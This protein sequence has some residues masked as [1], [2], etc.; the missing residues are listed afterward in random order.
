MAKKCSIFIGVIF[1]LSMVGLWG[2]GRVLETQSA[3]NYLL[4]RLNNH[5][6]GRVSIGSLD[7][8]LFRGRV[9][10]ENLTVFGPGQREIARAVGLSLDLSWLGFLGGDLLIESIQVDTPKIVLEAAQ[11]GALN[12]SSVFMDSP[13]GSVEKMKPSFSFPLNIRLASL[14]MTNGSLSLDQKL[15]SINLTSLAPEMLQWIPKGELG[16]DLSVKGPLD[17]PAIYLSLESKGL[18]I[19]GISIRDL[20]FMAGMQNQ[21]INIDRFQLE[22]DLG[23]FSIDGSINLGSMFPK[24]FLQGADP[25]NLSYDLKAQLEGLSPEGLNALGLSLPLDIKDMAGSLAAGINIKGAGILPGSI[26]ADINADAELQG[27]LYQDLLKPVGGTLKAGARLEGTHASLQSLNL[28]LPCLKLTGTGSLDMDT[29]EADGKFLLAVHALDELD[30]FI[31]VGTKG[32][33][34]TEAR[35]KGILPD[36]KIE[37]IAQG[38][39]LEIQGIRLGNMDL[40]ADLESDGSLWIDQVRLENQDGVL[41]GSGRIG[42]FD[43]GFDLKESL[44]MDMKLTLENLPLSDFLLDTDME[45]RLNGVINLTGTLDSPIVRT[46]VKG[47]DLAFGAVVFG[48]ASVEGH[49]E[50]GLFSIN[51]FLLKNKESELLAIGS[52]RILDSDSGFVSNPVI[53]LDIQGRGILFQDLVPD[54]RGQVDLDAQLRGHLFDPLVSLSLSGHGIGLKTYE[55]G[56][57]TLAG[58]LKKGQLS[59]DRG[60]VKNKQS[61][62]DLTASVQIFDPVTMELKPDPY[63]ALDINEGHIFLD[64]FME[65]AAGTVTVFGNVSGQLSNMTGRLGMKTGSLRVMGQAM[66]EGIVEASVKGQTIEIDRAE[67]W[68]KN[69]SVIKA[70]GH[71]TPMTQ[72]FDIRVNSKQFN[73]GDLTLARQY[74]ID[75]GLVSLD[76]EARGRFD[77]PLV[78]ADIKVVDL[79]VQGEA[80]AGFDLGLHLKEQT[81]DIQGHVRDKN[82]PVSDK[83]GQGSAGGSKITGQYHL[84]TQAFS[85]ALELKNFYLSPYFSLAGRP[86]FSGLITGQFLAQGLAGQLDHINV[87]ADVADLNVT[88]A[89]QHFLSM[90]NAGFSIDDGKIH[91]PPVRISLYKG[92]IIQAKGLGDMTGGLDF[93][94][95]GEV[96]LDM[97]APLVP[98]VESASGTISMEAFVSGSLTDPRIR[99]TLDL[100]NLGLVLDGIE[101]EIKHVKG[102]VQMD[103]DQIEII[104]VA[105]NLDDGRFDLNG[106]VGI[107]RWAPDTLDLSLKSR[108][109]EVDIPDLMEMS[110]NLDL[111]LKGTARASELKGAV[112]ILQGRYYR[113]V[114]LGLLAVA[115]SRTRTVDPIKADDLPGFLDTIHLNVNLVR[116]EPILIENN[117]ANLEVSP[118]LILKGRATA[119]LVQGRAKVDSGI[120]RFQ[121]TEFE[122]KKGVIDFIN[123]YKIEPDI[124]VMGE[125]EIRNWTITIKVRGTPEDLNLT[126]ESIPT[127]EH[128]DIISLI[129]FGKTTRELRASDG[130]GRFAPEEILAAMVSQ[131]LQKSIKDSTGLDYFEVKTDQEAESGDSRVNVTMGADLSR[132]ITVKYGV[133]VRKGETVHRVTTSYKLLE[134]LLMNG[135]QE[136]DGQFGG[137]LKYRLEF[138]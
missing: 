123:P 60:L 45:G 77:A 36:P 16:F 12:L 51:R 131:S 127:E 108:Q 138:R 50:K 117:L 58:Q 30:R 82:G 129:A 20:R 111:T 19:Y 15:N 42:I 24:G 69:R 4:E 74:S 27:I 67:L 37:V 21:E 22:S 104:G 121:S 87:Q 64:D 63:L 102:R 73:L 6:P 25:D 28:D 71:L 34:K 97:I 75:A 31:H 122:V 112:V 52:A 39:D 8:S 88:W 54:A 78:H 43:R 2:G 5:I 1:F 83:K 46:N 137:E 107:K 113:D 125:A 136:T 115:A 98:R 3:G 17:N 18:D 7:V 13:P 110:T 11:D 68:L 92:G 14:V 80:Q 10:L 41:E 114:D 81:L 126:F 130:G 116:Q 96:P 72:T 57:F 84:D 86:G 106:N 119:P 61:R 47:K 48:N 128:A 93:S 38:S 124:D 29:M 94:A 59:I 49:L 79:V 95:Q 56:D 55:L 65:G 76:L 33:L 26:M 32:Q 40:K 101:Q 35:I 132:Q 103:Q 44:P 62:L 120:L 66:E 133:R 135:Y 89:D 90:G 9:D 109:L 100:E 91:L 23:Q 105:G 70:E 134:N 53:H 85:T 99:A 118:D